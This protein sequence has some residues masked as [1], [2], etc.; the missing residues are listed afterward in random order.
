[1]LLT[2]EVI[3]EKVLSLGSGQKARRTGL[4]EE[5]ERE[6]EKEIECGNLLGIE[7]LVKPLL[8]YDTLQSRHTQHCKIS[9]SKEKIFRPELD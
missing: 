9:T 2:L 5:C 3:G 7:M 1:M 6:L 4:D 8:T